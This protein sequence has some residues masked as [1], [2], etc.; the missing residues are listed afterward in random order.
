MIINV[1]HDPR[2]ED[3]LR[4]LEQVVRQTPVELK[5]WPA[6]HHTHKSFVGIGRA[7]KNIVASALINK[8]PMICIAED[9]FY[10][11]APGAWDHFL[12]TIPAQFDLYLASI[13]QG[14]IDQHQR[15]TDFCG[16]TLYIIHERFYQTFLNLKE[17]GHIDRTLSGK[18][19]FVVC[20]PFTALQRHGYSDNKKRVVNYTLN[21]R[22]RNIFGQ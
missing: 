16:L 22:G 14:Q 2:R 9:D 5:F 7:H 8:L 10:F 11:P 1:I 18:G 4:S 13:Y 3:R 20:D 19:D 21:L 17:N 6:V 12:N 15:T